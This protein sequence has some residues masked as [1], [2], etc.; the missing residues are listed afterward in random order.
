MATNIYSA[1]IALYNG[2]ETQFNEDLQY[3]EE[4]NTGE[5]YYTEWENSN[6][7]KLQVDDGTQYFILSSHLN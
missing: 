2:D 1:H 6:A 4:H 3:D 7:T 5:V